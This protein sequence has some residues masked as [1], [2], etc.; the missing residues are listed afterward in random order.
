MI[1]G[2]S[3]VR[4]DTMKSLHF[5]YIF[6]NLGTFGGTLSPNAL[7]SDHGLYVLLAVIVDSPG[8]IMPHVIER[9]CIILNLRSVSKSAGAHKSQPTTSA[10]LSSLYAFSISD[11]LSDNV[12]LADLSSARKSLQAIRSYFPV[13][14]YAAF[15]SDD[16]FAL[17]QA[18]NANILKIRT[19]FFNL[20]TPVNK[21]FLI[22]LFL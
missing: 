5:L 6:H 7:S 20:F 22:K 13:G 4:S 11:V 2:L 17:E 14:T 3:E 9:F 12:L 19:K 18:L 1:T 8:T 15:I 21:A 10:A 16:D